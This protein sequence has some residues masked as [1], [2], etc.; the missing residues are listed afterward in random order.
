MALFQTDERNHAFII[1]IAGFFGVTESAGN[2]VDDLKKEVSKIR[3][4]DYKLIVDSSD[5]RTF[6]PEILP[7]LETS[8]GLYMSLGFQRILM[9]TPQRV[10]PRLQLRRIAKKTKFTGE[11]VE[12][13]QLAL[14]E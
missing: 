2:F 14:K 8:Y 12:N 3:V 7:V 10:T 5:L 11:F 1:T 6:K 9:V 4:R 13:L